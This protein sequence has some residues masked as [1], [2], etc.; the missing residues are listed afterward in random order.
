MQ[1]ART[2]LVIIACSP[3]GA[4][5]GSDPSSISAGGGSAAVGGKSTRGTV[6]GSLG[7][8]GS[9]GGSSNRGGTNGLLAG[10]S[11]GLG[12]TGGAAG[13]SNTIS[14]GGTINATGGTSATGGSSSTGGSAAAGGTL[15]TGGSNSMGGSAAM[16]GTLATGGTPATGGSN[17]V[18]VGGSAAVGG[19]NGAGGT[20][21]TGG[22]N[23]VGGSV[24]AGGTNGSGGSAATG[25]TSGSG[26]SGPTVAESLDIADVWSGQPVF[27]ALV[28]RNNQQFVAY[29]DAQRNMTVASRTLGNTTWTYKVLPSMLGWDSHNYVAMALDSTNQIHVSGNMHAVPLVYFKSTTASDISTIATSTMVGA[30][31]TSVTYP[32]FF[33]GPTGNLVFEYRDGS[34][35]NGNTIF[36]SYSTTTRTW[37]RTI[38]TPL[39]DGT[40]SSMNAYPEGPVLGPDGYYHL[41]W[42]WRDT[43]DASTN[44]DLSYA[45]TQDLV[46]WYKGDG[47]P[48][49]LP[50]TPSTGDIVDPVPVNGGMINNNTR[51]GFDAQNRPIIAYHKFDNGTSGNT[52]LYE[53][54]LE[55]GKWVIY[56]ATD[57]TY[58]WAFSGTG[59]LVFQ[60]SIDEGAKVLSDGR[61]I[62]NY[63]HSQY[64]GQGTLILNPTTLH[65]DQT[66]TPPLRPYPLTLDTPE[67][68]YLDPPTQQGMVVR[69][70]ADSGSGPDSSVQY[71]LRWETLPSNND[72]ARTDTP[73][74]TRLR[75]YGFKQ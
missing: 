46:H 68:T 31:E 74:A 66:L 29:Y 44:H 61:L 38:N 67:S 40:S 10:G 9:V 60:I 37:T 5:T 3:I 28:T 17:S 2:L 27:F 14:S 55:N 53:A 26:G 72:K 47:T 43:S 4:C 1:R 51:V 73:P 52:Q 45:K 42:V 15:A 54:R 75:L 71:M 59:T 20:P 34:S 41:V 24:A 36:N 56:K 48:I 35:G 50:I 58:R 49:T 11:S 12:G 7:Q 39:L 8:G 19:T 13:A 65:A 16:G 62:Q 69:W 70:Q 63:Y 23:S 32:I 33:N 64:G 18:G 30:N 21:A 25:G 22:S 6:G 57:W